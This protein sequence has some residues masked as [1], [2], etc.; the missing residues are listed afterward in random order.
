VIHIDE[1]SVLYFIFF[2]TFFFLCLAIIIWSYFAVLIQSSGTLA[3]VPNSHNAYYKKD[4]LM[5]FARV[6]NILVLLWVIEFIIGCQHMIIAGSVATWFFSRNKDNVS[7]PISTSVG[8]LF[9][10]HLGSVALGS[11]IITIFQ[12]I[13]AILNY[14]D[15]TLKDSENEV[16]RAFYKAFKCLFQCLQ[17]FLQYLTRNAYIEIGMKY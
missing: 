2:Q 17:Q 16:A 6:Y 7:S 12:I 8:Y 14:I 10:Y 4:Q 9:N 11:F 13:N 3:L 1:T 15:E 5:K